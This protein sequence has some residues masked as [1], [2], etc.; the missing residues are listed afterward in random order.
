MNGA[1]NVEPVSYTPLVMSH[2]SFNTLLLSVV[3]AV[4][5]T[6]LATV[7]EATKPILDPQVGA[8]DAKLVFLP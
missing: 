4:D 1:V 7:F 8:P 6:N 2:T 5:Q 3:C